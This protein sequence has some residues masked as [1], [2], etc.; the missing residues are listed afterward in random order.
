[1][2]VDERIGLDIDYADKSNFVYDLWIMAN[3]PQ[4]LFQKANS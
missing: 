3:T 4:A 2:S 1:M